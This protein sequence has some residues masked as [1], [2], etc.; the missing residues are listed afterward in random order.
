VGF[1]DEAVAVNH[2]GGVE[3]DREND[4]KVVRWGDVVAADF[5]LVLLQLAAL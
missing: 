3:G 1:R 4:G 2:C 5:P